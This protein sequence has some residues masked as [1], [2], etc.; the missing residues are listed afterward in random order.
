MLSRI[1][2][3]KDHPRLNEEQRQEKREQGKLALEQLLKG[4]KDS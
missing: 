4:T 2:V 3:M 1:D